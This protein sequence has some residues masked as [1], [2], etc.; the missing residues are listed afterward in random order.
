LR[1][2]DISGFKDD[3]TNSTAE[4]SRLSLVHT[5]DAI[6][7]VIIQRVGESIQRRKTAKLMKG[8]DKK[9][10]P[11]KKASDTESEEPKPVIVSTQKIHSEQAKPKEEKKPKQPLA[12]ALLDSVSVSVR[13]GDGDDLVKDSFARGTT[14]E[15]VLSKLLS[16][17][18]VPWE[19]IEI[20]YPNPRSK[21]TT[22]VYIKCVE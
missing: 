9:Q 20:R 19:N 3:A 5:N 1:L 14:L 16:G 2:L 7:S 4:A 10:Q 13:I 8:S 21:L 18:D 12:K 22:D 11:V 17:R 6:L 15:E